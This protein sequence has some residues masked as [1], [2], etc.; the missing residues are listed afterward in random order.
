MIAYTLNQHGISVITR[1]YITHG[2][3]TVK[4]LS[5]IFQAADNNMNA[6]YKTLGKFNVVRRD[7]APKLYDGTYIQ[8]SVS[9]NGLT[10]EEVNEITAHLKEQ[11]IGKF[12]RTI[13]RKA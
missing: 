2:S 8:G 13:A 5:H 7:N 6:I 11:G 1:E 3:L 9:V 10:E 4:E 12:C